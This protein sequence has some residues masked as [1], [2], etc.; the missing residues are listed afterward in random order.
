[1]IKPQKERYEGG[2]LKTQKLR[3]KEINE[4]QVDG[5]RRQENILIL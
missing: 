3:K 4:V 2:F 1:V 5:D